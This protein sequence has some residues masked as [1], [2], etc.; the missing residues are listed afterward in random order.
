[1]NSVR[2]VS[3]ARQMGLTIDHKTAVLQVTFGLLLLVSIVI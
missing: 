3:P 2:T 1:M